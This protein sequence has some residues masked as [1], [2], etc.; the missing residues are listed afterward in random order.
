MLTRL[1]ELCL[2]GCL[3]Q[4]RAIRVIRSNPNQPLE[5]DGIATIQNSSV[6]SLSQFTLCARIFTNQF[7]SYFSMKQAML[8]VSKIRLL[9]SFSTKADCEFTGCRKY[10]KDAVGD[11]WKYGKTYGLILDTDYG[12]IFYPA[13]KPNRW[14]KLCILVDS[15]NTHIQI[16][17]GNIITFESKE[18]IINS[19]ED[20]N[21]ILLNYK[22]GLKKNPMNGAITDV[23]VWNRILTK[24][25]IQNWIDC[26]D[27]E[28]G[29]IVNWVTAKVN[30]E[31]LDDIEI[32]RSSICK[33]DLQSSQVKQLA[34]FKFKTNTVEEH[35]NFCRSLG[36]NVAV[37][38]NEYELK[39]IHQFQI[40]DENAEFFFIGYIKKGGIWVNINNN[41]QMLWPESFDLQTKTAKCVD[42]NGTMIFSDTCNFGYYPVCESDEEQRTFQLRGVCSNIKVDTF[43]IFVNATYML[44]Y[45]SSEIIL[46]EKYKQWEIRN[47]VSGVVSAIMNDTRRFPIGMNKWYFINET[48]RDSV[49]N[50]RHMKMHLDVDEPGNFCCNDGSC[51]KS[52]FVCDEI[53][54]CKTFEDEEG[55]ELILNPLDKSTDIP[56]IRVHETNGS[57]IRAPVLASVKIYKLFSVD[58]SAGIFEILFTVNLKWKNQNL[59]YNYLKETD[60]VNFFDKNV[61]WTPNINF[62]H[63]KKNYDYKGETFIKRNMSAKPVLSGDTDILKVRE[64]YN[65]E[66]HYIHKIIR[67]RAEFMCSFDQIVLYPFGNQECDMGFYIEGTDSKMTSLINES[68]LQPNEYE[69]GEYLIKDWIFEVDNDSEHSILIVKMVLTRK[70]FG[71]FMVTYLPTILMNIINQASNHSKT[72]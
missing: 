15:L 47:R 62:F 54:H 36:F 42:S 21:I 57:I 19:F 70:L 60:A 28:G 22:D 35:K 18:K 68:F 2:F 71:I 10:Y 29:N 31:L 34:G 1:T 9:W 52:E 55:C 14:E 24:E 67:R 50:Y 25:D 20:E 59:Q 32:D 69:I 33:N 13:W 17:N 8:T 12:Y 16:Y 5:R 44:G 49:G 41:Q 72:C 11:E 37:A 40:G 58:Q 26:K 4:S 53:H 3:I 30:V 48:C 6:A 56:P 63:M 45:T 46:N 23:N 51:I 66:D 7:D 39:E 27:S 65:G 64:I 38:E 61:T 43:Y